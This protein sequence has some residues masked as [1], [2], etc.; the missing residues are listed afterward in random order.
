MSNRHTRYYLSCADFD[1]RK[2]LLAEVSARTGWEPTNTFLE[3]CDAQ[4]R[5][6]LEDLISAQT[7]V[8]VVDGQCVAQWVD[9]GIAV[10]AE[11]P[12]VL[13]HVEGLPLPMHC[14]LEDIRVVPWSGMLGDVIAEALEQEDEDS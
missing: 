9:V 10:G 7:V 2:S 8:V 14:E 6:E 3:E 4:A 12:V 5:T 11:I 13:V 1:L